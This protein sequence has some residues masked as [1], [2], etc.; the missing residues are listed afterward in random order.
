AVEMAD[1]EIPFIAIEDV[2]NSKKEMKITLINTEAS[3]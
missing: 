3:Y 2:A 1:T